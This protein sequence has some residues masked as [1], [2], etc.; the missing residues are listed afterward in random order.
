MEKRTNDYVFFFKADSVFSNFHDVSE[1]PI[2]YNGIK[3]STSEHAFMYM[4]ALCFKDQD[5]MNALA[6]SFGTHPHESKKLGRK[7]R[8]FDDAKWDSVR[9]DVMVAVLKSKFSHPELKAKLLNTGE[10]TLVEASPFDAIWGVKMD[11]N[12][13][14]ILQPNKWR[15]QNLL[16]KA[17]MEV[18]A[19]YK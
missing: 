18:R 4:K 7:V 16:G 3:F 2:V 13:D 15:G 14:L 9:Y 17:L 5:V 19:F 1:T 10:R 12:N 8:N 6:N 11:M